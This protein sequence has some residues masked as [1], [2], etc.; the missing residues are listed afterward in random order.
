MEGR[1]KGAG[2]GK[3][4]ALTGSSRSRKADGRAAR[5]SSKGMV[6]RYLGR[7]SGIGAV[8][9][10]GE[11]I[12]RVSYEFD[13]FLQRPMRITSS[14]EIRAPAAILKS[15]FGGTHIQLLTDDGRLLDL[16]FSGKEPSPTDEVAQVDVTGELPTM[17]KSWRQNEPV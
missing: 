10:G 5:H 17:P 6:M 2:G 15:L 9:S 13:G 16:R 7:L 1:G 11:E 3:R 4:C 12:A 8:K 14:G